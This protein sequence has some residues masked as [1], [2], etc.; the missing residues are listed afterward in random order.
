MTPE[1]AWQEEAYDRM[2]AEVLDAHKGDIAD[3]IINEF[4]SERMGSYYRDHPDLTA[5]AEAA[6]EEARNLIN[7]SPTASLVFSRSAVEMTLRDVLLKPIAFGM[8]HNQT[9]GPLIAELVVGNRHFTRLLFSILEGYG[10]DLKHDSRRGSSK[11]LWAEMEE[12]KQK[13]DRIVHCGEKTS[14]EMAKLSLEIATAL[15]H[16]LYPHLRKVIAGEVATNF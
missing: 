7:V 15:L 13:R 14:H 9:T 8:V 5:P 6:I 4:V 10:L 2:V 3:D 12:I 1:D 11:N 16:K